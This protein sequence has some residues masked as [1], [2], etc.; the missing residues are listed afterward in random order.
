MIPNELHF[1]NPISLVIVKSEFGENIKKAK[2]IIP[3]KNERYFDGN[4]LEEQGVSLSRKLSQV[5]EIEFDTIR[6]EDHFLNQSQLIE[7]SHKRRFSPDGQTLI[8][9]SSDI[10][11]RF[12]FK[13]YSDFFLTKH[14][15][16]HLWQAVE[17]ARTDLLYGFLIEGTK[18]NLKCM[19]S[20]I[21]IASVKNL[22]KEI[23]VQYGDNFSS[24][25]SVDNHKSYLLVCPYRNDQVPE[26]FS[27]KFFTYVN[28]VA[29]KMK[30]NIVI[31]NHPNDTFD[32]RAYFPYE[33]QI[34]NFSNK[35]ERHI[36]VE[37]FLQ[38]NQ[39][40]HTIS[41]PSS[42][43]AFAEKERLSVLVPANRSL[44]RNK[45]LDQEP[46]LKRLNLHVETI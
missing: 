11:C 28:A 41:V 34:M 40:F 24:F 2:F 23:V 36:P 44:Y 10:Y 13:N 27:R 19:T 8:M 33:Q 32:Y 31:K 26:K 43:L 20:D 35:S 15:L 3:T 29:K 21:E 37:F 42:S 7:A 6:E 1:S 25:F 46:F 39:V 38:S 5:L 18:T 12:G 30:L 14:K 17:Y 9:S 22:L 16:H 45:F 4:R